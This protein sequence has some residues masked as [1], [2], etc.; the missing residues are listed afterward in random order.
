M[1]EAARVIKPEGTLIIVEYKK[2]DGPPGPPKPVRLSPQEVDTLVSTYGFRQ[3]HL[4][5]IG[6]SHYM[7]I[8][9]KRK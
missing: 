8:F 1:Q 4:T 6:D 2:T 7:Q 3:K 5:E 9:A